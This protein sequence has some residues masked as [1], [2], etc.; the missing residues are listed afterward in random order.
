M[1]TFSALPVD[2][3]FSAAKGR[4]SVGSWFNVTPSHA[5]GSAEITTKDIKHDLQLSPVLESQTDEK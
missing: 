3:L 4:L 5:H 2:T 1:K